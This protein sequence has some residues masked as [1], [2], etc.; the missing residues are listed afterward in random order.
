MVNKSKT[1][2][3]KFAHNEISLYTTISNIAESTSTLQT[4]S[5]L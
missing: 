2:A 5:V 3:A 1:V 4:T